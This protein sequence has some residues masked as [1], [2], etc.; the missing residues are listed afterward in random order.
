MHSPN[1][2]RIS[3]KW[4]KSK[5]WRRRRTFRHPPLG[6]FYSFLNRFYSQQLR[7]QYLVQQFCAILLCEQEGKAKRKEALPLTQV[8]TRSKEFL[9][10]ISYTNIAPKIW[11]EYD[12]NWRTIRISVIKNSQC[13]EPLLACSILAVSHS[14]HENS[15]SIPRWPALLSCCQGAQFSSYRSSLGWW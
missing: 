7:E 12:V 11:A 15:R 2:R 8:W 14:W 13:V 10:V 3:S 1:F 4:A 9:S 6:Q 5:E